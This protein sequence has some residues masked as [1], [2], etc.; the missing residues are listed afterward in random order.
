MER[1]NLPVELL[2]KVPPE[3]LGYVTYLENQLD[4][5]EHLVKGLD[6]RLNLNSQNSSKPPSS[7]PPAPPEKKAVKSRAGNRDIPATPVS[8]YQWKK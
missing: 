2:Q 3:I 8:F 4:V 7:D 6:A 1:P 5:L